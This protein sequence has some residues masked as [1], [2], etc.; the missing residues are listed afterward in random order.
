MA[1]QRLATATTAVQA[2]QESM[3]ARFGKRYGMSEDKF[4]KAL[5][6]V[7]YKPNDKRQLSVEELT[8]FLVVCEQYSL[9]PFLKEIYPAISPNNGLLPVLGVD[10]WLKQLNRHPDFDG[11][12]V[13]Y[14]EEEITVKR[15]SLSR[16]DLREH[17]TS[18]PKW[19]KVSI[20]LKEKSHPIVV[21]EY[22]KEV[23]MPTKEWKD[24]PYRMLRHKTLIQ[25]IRIACGMSGVY[26][27]EEV[28]TMIEEEHYE[29]S[30]HMPERTTQA[31]EQL[32][33][34]VAPRQFGDEGKRDLY[35][36]RVIER[37]AQQGVTAQALD[38]FTE[39]LEGEDL[40]YAVRKVQER[41]EADA[42]A[43]IEDAKEVNAS[44]E[45][46]PQGKIKDEDLP[47]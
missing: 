7:I 22:L 27:R 5:V 46:L 14:S 32:P 17:V 18:G 43:V 30:H 2:Q 1:E 8:A 45:V 6:S 10:G 40:R 42:K 24:K 39:T 25:G 12:E 37:C 9:N 19:C 3:L 26:D 44:S 34:A 28:N 47:F 31:V 29:S 35:V 41:I 4:Y 16:T 20:Y 36:Q 33:K 23:F 21:K 11:V 15:Q 38:F 13:E